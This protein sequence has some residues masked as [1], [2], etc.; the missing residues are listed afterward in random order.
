MDVDGF[1][2]LLSE[3]GARALAEAAEVLAANADP[4]A[5]ATALR[6]SYG[7][8]LTG[9]ALTMARLRERG[10]AKFGDDAERMFFTPHGLEQSTRRSVAEHRARRFARLAAAPRPAGPA[11]PAG[12]G[13]AAGVEPAARSGAED[14]AGAVPGNGLRVAEGG[15]GIGGDLIA[16]ARAGFEVDA[17]DLDPLTVEV[18]RANA[19]ALGLAGRVTVNVGD[20]ASLDPA[21]YDAFFADPARRAG[22][23]RRIFDPA[24]YSPPF[25]RIVEMASAAPAAC[26]KVAPGIPHELVP[27]GAGA[28]WVS[29]R[30]EVKEAA[31][32][33]GELADGVRRRATLLPG[34]HTL[35]PSA[36][37]P[38]PTGDPG[39]YLYEPDGAVIRAHLVAEVAAEVGGRLLDPRVAYISSD[40]LADT[41]WASAYEVLDVLPFSLKR[42]RAALRE[43]GTGPVTIKKRGS[44]VDVERLRK[45]LRLTGE[46]PAT[47]VLTRIG[48]RPYALICAATPHPARSHS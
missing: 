22:T 29:D 46:H 10:R 32:W 43:R 39:R 47:V 14:A 9:A 18:A 28:E 27:E 38:P 48:A 3:E 23:G 21:A 1:R 8:E 36:D 35:T 41:P 11:G 4:V 40:T 26:V 33:F 44:A 25:D 42:L 2:G 12:P 34:G 7:P 31:L 16:L 17:V 19:H 13:R 15:C 5:A 6:R 24:S 37:A 45:D 20:A 30:G